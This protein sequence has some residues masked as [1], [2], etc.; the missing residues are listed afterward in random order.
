LLTN[1]QT[2]SDLVV[3]LVALM[4]E[5]K[6]LMGRIKPSTTALHGAAKRAGEALSRSQA[7][8]R[9]SA[10]SAAMAEDV[11]GGSTPVTPLGAALGPGPSRLV[12]KKDTSG[13]FRK[14]DEMNKKFGKF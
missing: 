13:V 9:R 4:R 10:A 12:G 8:D 14:I 2:V 1:S 3:K 11:T 5:D 7:S 6:A